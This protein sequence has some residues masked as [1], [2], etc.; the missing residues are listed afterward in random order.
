M[1]LTIG[2]YRN[3]IANDIDGLVRELQDL[4]GRTGDEERAA[5]KNSLP[6]LAE[7]LSV[8]QLKD[9]HLYFG[10]SG[11]L[12]V[13]YQMPAAASWCDV[14][15]L[16]RNAG[17]RS[18]VIIEL[19]H[20]L[21]S[22]DRPG[23]AEGLIKRRD[24][25][26]LHPSE[27][28]RGYTEYCRRFHTAV[29]DSDASVDG[30]VLF[31]RFGNVG[32]YLQA[33][34]AELTRD[35]P[36][37]TTAANDVDERFPEYTAAR[38]TD[39]DPAFAEAFVAGDYRQDRGFVA[40]IGRQLLDPED[41]PFVLLENQRAALALCRER[42]TRYLD[43]RSAD[44]GKRVVI[45]EGP[46]GSGKSVVAAKLWASLVTDSTVREGDLVF[47]TT[48]QS[49]N[50]N[51]ERLFREAGGHRGAS[52]VV[53]K[54]NQYYPA[55]TQ[56]IGRLRRIHS[57][58]LF[59]DPQLWRRYLRELCAMRPPRS[60][61]EDDGYLVSI[62]DEAHALINPEHSN[63]RGQFGFA[64]SLGPQ[65]YHIIR[66]SRLTVLF[67]DPE[68]GFRERENTTLEDIRTW[69]AELGAEIEE[70]SLKDTQFRCAGSREYV[71]WLSSVFS[72][73]DARFAA[74]LAQR[75]RTPP[76]YRAALTRGRRVA[77][78]PAVYG[79]RQQRGMTFEIVESPSELEDALRT[80]IN[81]DYSARLLASYSR[82]WSTRGFPDPHNAPEELWDFRIPCDG[83]RE[84][85]RPW[86]V[87][88]NGTDYTPFVQA[89]P[90]SRMADD[91]LCEVGCTYAVRGFDFDYVGLLWMS[92]L[93]WRNGRWEV[94]PEHVYESGLRNLARAA[95]NRP[96]D[97]SLQEALLKAV[98]QAYRILLTRAL[99]GIY[100]WVE[101]N[102]TRDHLMRCTASALRTLR[103]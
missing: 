83:G 60:G 48:S 47:T 84:W 24:I 99:K 14:V 36:V 55:T 6:A 103:H 98:I 9:V 41:D 25:D 66:C 19:K 40:Q 18:V 28:V 94:Q 86:N 21:L 96:H 85:R 4:T 32:S 76:G 100:L 42:T 97:Q 46:P 93:V 23:S 13:E 5:W 54:A 71:E 74:R 49:Q 77:E 17:R 78:P 11:H 91:P 53:K 26:E 45:V 29:Q 79:A 12:D 30:C 7:M 88:A 57:E 101:D 38:I 16:G 65:A 8:P 63:G 75:W 22:G 20:W 68:Q 89:R 69:A 3:R 56:D 39:P 58:T 31:T 43:H 52:G 82:S 80:H 62:V 70:I 33:P 27:Q 59:K 50:S 1:L 37:F 72:N 73:M 34:N 92:D 44:P 67:L 61:A 15:L 2:E 64:S 35:F 81:E 51:W 95:Q 87:I 102:E 90:G 10:G